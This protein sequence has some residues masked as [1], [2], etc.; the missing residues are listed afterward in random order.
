[1]EG[2]MARIR[3]YKPE[4]LRHEFLQ[5]LETENPGKYPMFVF[6]GLWAV[7]DK[8]GVFPWKPR[9]LKL[10]IYPFL[11]FD[12]E[13]TLQILLDAGFIKKFIAE[14]N[15]ETYGHVLNFE[16]HQRITGDEGKNPS[17]YPPYQDTSPTQS[18]H[19]KDTIK[20]QSRHIDE[21]GK[22]KEGKGVKEK[23]EE[24]R[25]GKEGNS[26][27]PPLKNLP[28]VFEPPD[29]P[30]KN[31]S[32][33]FEEVK[34][35]WKEVTGQETREFL[36]T[37]PPAKREK[38]INTLANYRMDEIVNAMRNYWYVRGHPE[39]YDIGVR[40]YGTLYGFLENGVSQF[41]DD[42]IAS[43]NFRRQKK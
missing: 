12:M 11:D 3:T 40:I 8:Q 6:L 43:S 27:S 33:I 41:V 10:D 34:A 38:F 7:C 1:M 35:R 28:E 42:D 18:R 2:K 17:K 20:T 9:S 24:R 29:L 36:L 30:P 16:K 5:H 19:T 31:Y 37:I 4:F 21:N 22:G 39:D 13:E 32:Q 14:E 25:E 23:E 15:Q 26:L